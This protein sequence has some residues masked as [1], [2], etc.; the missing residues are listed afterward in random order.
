M[1]FDLNPISAWRRMLAQPNDSR[2]KTIAVAFVTAAVCALLV[3]AATVTLRPIQTANRAAEQQARLESLIAAIPGMSD[4]LAQSGDAALST[5]VVD[6]T[7]GRAAADITPETLPETLANPASHSALTPAQD[8]AD[9]GS[10]PDYAQIFIL[11]RGDSGPV[12]LVILPVA[13]AGYDGVI[14]AMVA[15]RG[16]TRSIAGMTVTSQSETPG[17]G[18]RITEPAWQ[19]QFAG[20]PALDDRGTVRFAVARGRAATEYEVDGITGA[21]RTSNAI[22]NMMRFW[23]GPDGYGPLLDAIR[24]GEF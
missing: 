8:L 12:D 20:L 14:Q 24:R 19:A 23:L 10:R 22:T 2:G 1:A 15:L 17:L 9:L 16:D 11:R 18:A 21:T 3:T 4:L 7:T 5:V 13:G 6:L